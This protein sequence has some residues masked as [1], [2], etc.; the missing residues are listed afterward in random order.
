MIQ[1]FLDFSSEDV[2]QRCFFTVQ[3]SQRRSYDL[4]RGFVGAGRQP[5][6]DTRLLLAERHVMGLL[7]RM[8]PLAC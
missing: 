3:R 7:L 5:R 2:V 1:S 4:T 6:V 8:M